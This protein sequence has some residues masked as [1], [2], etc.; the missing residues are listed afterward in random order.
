MSSPST[1]R[2]PYLQLT[3]ALAW[4]QPADRVPV[5]CCCGWTGRRLRRATLR[6]PCPSC[7][8]RVARG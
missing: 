4:P 5:R 6:R 1:M 2:Q 3:L 8:G 7:T